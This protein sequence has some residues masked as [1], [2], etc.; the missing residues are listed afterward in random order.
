M[1]RIIAVVVLLWRS[2][3]TA[4]PQTTLLNAG[5]SQ[6]NASGNSAFVA[7]LNETLADLRSSL[8]SAAAARFATAQRPRAADPVYALFQCRAY[9]SS[10]DCL[11][12]LS[13]AEARIRRCGNANG[14]RVIYD[15]CILRYESS[16]FFD[17]TTLPGN[18]GVC[19]G[20]AA[21]DAGFSEAAKALVRDLTS[22]TPRI[23]GFFAAA[24][25]D[26]V[27]AAAQC[28]ETVN[29]EGCSQC[30]TVA[31]ANIEGCPPD[32]DGRAVD[33]GC[34]MRYSSKSFFPANQTV[35][36]SQFL[37]SGERVRSESESEM[38]YVKRCIM[39]NA[40]SS[41]GI[42]WETS[43]V[44]SN[45]NSNKKGAIIG[46]VV[47]GICGLLLLAIIALL[48]IKRSRRRQGFR[49]GD[50][51]GATELQG[52]LNFHYKDLKAATNNFSEKNKLGEG[53]FG[54]VYKGTLKNGKT[55]AVKRLAIAQTRRAKA[56]FQSEVK[57]ISNVHHRNLVRLLGC[58]SKGQDLL[59]VYEYMANSSLNKFIFGDRHGFLNWKQRFNIIVGMAR[60]LAY[61]HQEFHVCIIHRDIKSSN[62]LLDDDFQPRIADFGLARLLPE[63]KSHL[64]TKFAGT[65]GYTA[66]EYAIHGQLSEKVDT[67]SF[68]VVVLEI[69][70][71]RKSNDAQLEPVTQYLLEWAW[72]LYESGDLINLVDKSLDPTEYSLEEMKRIIKIA[73]LC[74]QSTVSARPTMSEVVVLLLSEGDHNRLQPT[75]PTFIDATS[76]VRG[77]GSTSTGS[78]STSNATVSTSQFSAR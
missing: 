39:G 34:F 54:D 4:D 49:T 40:S 47:G 55:V 68:G 18:A 33:A 63:D 3:V 74:T 8:S 5:C 1:H 28:V 69:I 19:N 50:L 57:L 25:R 17:Q 62:I 35:D 72:K 56:D 16:T 22:A 11:A 21:S 27:F 46:G 76:R 58:S 14:A 48:W 29:E 65:L 37:S 44:D 67:Y 77:D 36:L 66:P 59:L 10:A 64:S 43:R 70:S 26:G 52:P 71:G 9:L 23:S 61:L 7:T 75:R 24:E 42:T 41:V 2:R 38:A 12:C 31:D 15:G 78:S 13:V 6:Y 20:S 45:R 73:L 60:G 32:T 51:L 53:G 30:L